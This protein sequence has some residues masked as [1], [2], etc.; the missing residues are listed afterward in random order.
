SDGG[1]ILFGLQPGSHTVRITAPGYSTAVEQ[2]EVTPGEL[3]FQQF[4][5]L[6]V[7]ATLAEVLVMA[8]PRRSEGASLAVVDGAADGSAQSAADLLAQ[9]VPGL[10]V[11]R[12]GGLG[13]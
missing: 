3:S 2:I 8:G 13:M 12:A 10:S 9:R 5:L 6:P 4:T 7:S 11:T 1:F